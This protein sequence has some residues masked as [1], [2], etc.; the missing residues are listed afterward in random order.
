VWRDIFIWKALHTAIVAVK[1]EQIQSL[2]EEL[3]AARAD[4]LQAD[5]SREAAIENLIEAMTP[6]PLPTPRFIRRDQAEPHSEPPTLDLAEVDPNDKIAIRNLALREMPTGK[7]SASHVL[8]KMESIRAQAIIAQAA[9][10]QRAMEPGVL[11]APES[12]MAKIEAAEQAG[13][14]Q[15]RVQ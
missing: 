6:K 3:A 4:R 2:R 5:A 13:R 9:K 11:S 8:Q 10:R 15:A 7:N 12:V 14:E 1:D